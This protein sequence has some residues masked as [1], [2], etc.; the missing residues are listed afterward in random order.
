[1]RDVCDTDVILMLGAL[2]TCLWVAGILL[3]I[4]S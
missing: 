4:V 3:W 2:V 1:M